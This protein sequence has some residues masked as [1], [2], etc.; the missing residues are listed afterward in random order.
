MRTSDEKYPISKLALIFTPLSPFEFQGV[1]EGIRERGLEKPIT[2]WRGEIIDGRHRYEAC[3]QTGVEPRFVELPKDANPFDRVMD[4]N[5]NRRHMSESQRAIAAHRVWELASDGWAALGLAGSE[6]ANLH[7]LTLQEAAGLFNVSRRLVIHAG[8]IFSRESLAVPELRQAADEGTVA[9][10]DAS[11][12]VNQ[13][14][15]I[16]LRAV[17]LVRS[18]GS[19][20][21]AGA[22]SKVMQETQDQQL[23]DGLEAVLPEH[24]AAS[25]TLH[26]SP[27]GDL[28]RLVERESVDAIITNPPTS[29]QS[30]SM[31]PDLAAFAAHSLKPSGVMIMMASVEHLPEVMEHLRHSEMHWVA[32]FDIVFDEPW[33][34]LQGKHRLDL[35]RRPLL[36]FGKPRFR[37]DGGDDLITVPRSEDAPKKVKQLIAGMRLIVQRITQPGQVV[38]DPIMLG[39]DTVASAALGAGC[40]FIGADTDQ[41]C[42]DRVSLRLERA[43]ISKVSTG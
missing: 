31:L 17:E 36:V 40:G 4:E 19:K 7:S 26:C 24:L 12:V 25:L 29:E 13:T 6:S 20:T 34:R 38:C 10:S 27:V 15:E 1:V 2:L 23:D 42:I 9:V 11:K 37:L 35:R 39:R 18:G 8:K 5:R 28:H 3:R 33:Y 14:A 43:G 22:V 16:Q 32:E 30:I 41:Y 21:I